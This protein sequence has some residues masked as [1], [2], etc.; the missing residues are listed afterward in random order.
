[1]DTYCKFLGWIFEIKTKSII[2]TL[3]KPDGAISKLFVDIEG[4]G[5][6]LCG[7]KKEDQENFKLQFGK[8]KAQ[9]EKYAQGIRGETL[10]NNK[11]DS[12]RA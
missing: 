4:R 6:K 5:L 3:C 7:E 8:V 12:V 11:S 10:T 2:N 1:M 9:V